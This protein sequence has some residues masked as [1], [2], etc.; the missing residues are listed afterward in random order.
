MN[1]CYV[2]FRMKLHSYTKTKLGGEW[3][4]WLGGLEGIQNWVPVFSS[5]RHSEG[6]GK[7]DPLI[8]SYSALLPAPRQEPSKTFCT[9][10]IRGL[11]EKLEKICNAL[12]INTAFKPA[13]TLRQT[14]MEVKIHVPEEKRKGVVYECIQRMDIIYE[15]IVQYTT[16]SQRS[17]PL[18]HALLQTF[19]T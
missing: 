6:H 10:Y 19:T 18:S 11:S 13:Q 12:G 4:I 14:L 9:P 2:E 8:P 16:G 7:E 3:G 1:Q 5:Q 17:S 15:S